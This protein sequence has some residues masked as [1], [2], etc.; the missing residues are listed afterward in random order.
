MRYNQRRK[1]KRRLRRS[2][3]ERLL[4]KIERAGRKS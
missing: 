1:R 4:D 2:L 3:T